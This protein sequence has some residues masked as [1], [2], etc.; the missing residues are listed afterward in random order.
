M[1]GTQLELKLCVVDLLTLI[2]ALKKTEHNTTH[3]VRACHA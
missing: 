1:H 3:K 2:T